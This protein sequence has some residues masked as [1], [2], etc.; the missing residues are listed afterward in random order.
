MNTANR[1]ML[2]IKKLLEQIEDECKF[3]LLLHENS[4][5]KQINPDI[6][7][8]PQVYFEIIKYI[9]ILSEVPEYTCA[10]RAYIISDNHVQR[11][12]LYSSQLP[13]NEDKIE[14]DVQWV[15]ALDI[16]D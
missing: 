13:L 15:N 6:T 3:S 5:A 10:V 12:E 1:K 4:Q 14:L 11:V 9:M 7:F 16:S 2:L 8:L